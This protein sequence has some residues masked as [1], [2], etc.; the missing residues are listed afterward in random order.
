MLNN[1]I[2]IEFSDAETKSRV[3]HFTYVFFIRV[4]HTEQNVFLSTISYI[5]RHKIIVN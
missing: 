4:F 2:E 1:E 3:F 5:F